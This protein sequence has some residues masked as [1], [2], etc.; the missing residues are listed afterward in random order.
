MKSMDIQIV[1]LANRMKYLDEVSE[2][3]WHEWGKSDKRKHEVHDYSYD[4]ARSCIHIVQKLCKKIHSKL[5]EKF[6]TYRYLMGIS[7]IN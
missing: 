4:A 1:N 2:W 3:F 5:R 7:S 6:L